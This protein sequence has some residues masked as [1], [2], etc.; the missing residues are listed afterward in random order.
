[1]RYKGRHT[2][3]NTARDNREL[4]SGRRENHKTKEG[5][6]DLC[7]PKGIVHNHH[8]LP[9]FCTRNDSMPGTPPQSRHS[10]LPDK[11][12]PPHT[13]TAP[14]NN[15]AIPNH[16]HKAQYQTHTHSRTR[17]HTHTHTHTHA[18]TQAGRHART[19]THTYAR[20][21]T[22][23]CTRGELEGEDVLD[24]VNGISYTGRKRPIMKKTQPYVTNN[25]T[26]AQTSNGRAATP[27]MT[28][29]PTMQRIDA[30]SVISPHR[31]LIVL[32]DSSVFVALTNARAV[33][34]GA[35][36]WH[37][38]LHTFPTQSGAD[39]TVAE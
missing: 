15:I 4:S 30:F 39:A 12:S 2:L 36:L 21:H 27:S 8:Y 23:T 26:H 33:S 6:F 1:M 7:S 19:R 18:R 5:N 9:A 35:G 16:T 17:V 3:Q 10:W 31:V 11:L 13:T 14:P 28:R 20:T 22:N 37:Q 32:L 38:W 24:R 25:S 34:D 29:A